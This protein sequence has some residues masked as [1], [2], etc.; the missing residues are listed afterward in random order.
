M[1]T[2]PWFRWRHYHPHEAEDPRLAFAA[3]V[4]IGRQQMLED[5]A[6]W[7]QLA[8]LLDSLLEELHHLRQEREIERE[9]ELSDTRDLEPAF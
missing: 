1:A 7:V 6:Q 8:P 3:G 4:R 9:I 2:D 5:S